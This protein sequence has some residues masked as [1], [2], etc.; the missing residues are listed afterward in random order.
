MIAG[1][2]QQ[3][4]EYTGN[5]PNFICTQVT[6]REMAMAPP[7]LL[8]VRESGGRGQP[9]RLGS[10]GAGQWQRVDAIE[11]QLSYFDRTESYKLQKVNGKTPAAGQQ[12]PPGLSSTGEFGTTLDGVFEPETQA[13]FSWKRW[14][15]LRGR[16]VAV[17]SYRVVQSRSLAQLSAGSSNVVVG[18]H[19]LVYADRDTSVVLRITTEAE[20]PGDFPLQDVTH[21]L[22]YGLA[23]IAD[24]Q[25][26]LPLHG[27]MQSRVSEDFVR[28][29]KLGGR[30]R[31]VMMRNE[32]D[33]RQ[34]RKY[35]AESEL[36]LDP[37]KP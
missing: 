13:E 1:I 33:F 6:R 24:K 20:A 23:L 17:F 7:D 37:D 10:S 3:A 5:L 29:G 21:V 36:K 8:G 32:I 18:Y 19:G 34:Y 15:T 31:Q 22:D 14:D 4:L 16:S 35:T 27:E 11:E 28:S 12:R 30:S 2:R 25:F 9:S 26:V